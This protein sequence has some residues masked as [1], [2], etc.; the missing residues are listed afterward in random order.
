[1]ARWL[2]EVCGE[3]FDTEEIPYWFPDGEA[4]AFVENA[5]TFLTGNA[6]EAC[7]DPG[8]VHELA[9]R[10]IDEFYAVI[11]LLQA[12]A[13]RPTVGKICRESDDGTRTGYVA[14]SA[15]R[16]A[17]SIVNEYIDRFLARYGLSTEYMKAEADSAW[18]LLN[19]ESFDDLPPQVH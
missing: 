15:L 9:D 10:I 6:F 14:I 18:Q 5:D 19:F 12:G 7:A 4:Y 11:C 13:R 16:I 8:E 3:K 17:N 1:M 2:I